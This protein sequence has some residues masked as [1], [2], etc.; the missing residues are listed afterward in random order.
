[1]VLKRTIASMIQAR[2]GLRLAGRERVAHPTRVKLMKAP[3][4]IH[5][6]LTREP[7]RAMTRSLMV[8]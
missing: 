3:R 6:V 8:M 4:V 5:A 7:V 1:M 2:L